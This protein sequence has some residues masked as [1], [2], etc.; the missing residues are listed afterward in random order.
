VIHGPAGGG[1]AASIQRDLH[2]AELRDVFWE[3]VGER[4]P[5]VKRED[6]L[7]VAASHL[8]S[9]V[10]LHESAE[11]RGEFLRLAG[12]I[13]EGLP[14]WGEEEEEDEWEGEGG[15]A[16]GLGGLTADMLAAHVERVG[17]ISI[18]D[19]LRI[20]VPASALEGVSGEMEEEARRKGGLG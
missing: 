3:R 19:A 14:G 10:P 1:R 13:M 4:Y 17:T 15:G 18:D 5:A 6:V 12:S 9:I 11:H 16:G 20:G 2:L 8:F 7:V